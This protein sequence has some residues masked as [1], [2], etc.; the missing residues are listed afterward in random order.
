MKNF[1]TNHT[2]QFEQRFAPVRVVRGKNL[3]QKKDRVYTRY[4]YNHTNNFG[5]VLRQY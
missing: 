5:H 4:H 2:N 1:T 3:P